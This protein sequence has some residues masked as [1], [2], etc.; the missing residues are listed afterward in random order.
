MLRLWF[1]I[2]IKWMQDISSHSIKNEWV[3]IFFREFKWGIFFFQAIR[4]SR[5]PFLEFTGGA[6]DNHVTV[7][8][9]TFWEANSI[10]VLEAD[11]GHRGTPDFRLRSSR[12]TCVQIIF[13]EPFST[14]ENRVFN[15]LVLLVLWNS[16]CNLF[17]D[18]SHVL[19]VQT[20][21]YKIFK[22]L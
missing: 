11:I 9:W 6:S 20:Y 19:Y 4:H 15:Y 1:C 14:L 2:W 13:W 21:S 10:S 18:I 17:W 5:L 16:I 3:F 22:I 12:S 7:G 8:H